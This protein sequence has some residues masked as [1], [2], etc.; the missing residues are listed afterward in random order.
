[1]EAAGGHGAYIERGR[2]SVL[3]WGH[4]GGSRA[5]QDSYFLPVWR[6][7]AGNAAG[8]GRKREAS[9]VSVHLKPR[10]PPMLPVTT[11]PAAVPAGQDAAVSAVCA[12]QGSAPRPPA[13]S[14]TSWRDH[15]K[16]A[17]RDGDAA[18]A[19]LQ[20]MGSLWRGAGGGI[21]EG[22]V[23]PEGIVVI[24]ARP[25]AYAPALDVT[26]APRA[27]GQVTGGAGLGIMSAILSPSVIGDALQRAGVPGRAVRNTSPVLAAETILTAPLHRG[28]MNMRA[29]WNARIGRSRETC[30]AYA[31]PGKSSVSAP[32]HYVGA[33]AIAHVLAAVIGPPRP[34]RQVPV[35]DL[36]GGRPGPPAFC[37]PACRFPL[38]AAAAAGNA[39]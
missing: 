2:F 5:A 27:A 33:K 11:L 35:P 36:A 32:C 21:E 3:R 24:G 10:G 29:V 13:V 31:L 9:A 26:A 30:A 20:A 6:H 17:P 38:P 7:A 34:A 39:S 12:G 14:R 1:G 19:E 28:T 18:L 4:R 16:T 8:R 25:G 23:P 37:C 15:R 22:P